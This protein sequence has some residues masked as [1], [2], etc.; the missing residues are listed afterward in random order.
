MRNSLRRWLVDDCGS[1]APRRTNV[2]ALVCVAAALAACG[3]ASGDLVD[4]PV[5]RHSRLSGDGGME[6]GIVGVLELDD[7][8]LYVASSE[9]SERYPILW[10]AE[11]RWDSKTETI[12]TPGETLAVGDRVYGS[13]GYF[14]PDEI[15]RFASTDAAAL[16]RRCVDNTY[17]EVAVVNNTDSAIAWRTPRQFSTRCEVIASLPNPPRVAHLRR[18]HCRRCQGLRTEP[19]Q[20]RD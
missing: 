7:G 2:A 14:T 9:S 8:C 12:V 1:S 3:S 18:R 17:G 11:T 4:G 6:A 15:E 13:G 10:P 5:M 16:A 20:R 19:V